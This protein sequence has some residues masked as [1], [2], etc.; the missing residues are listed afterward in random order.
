[1]HLFKLRKRLSFWKM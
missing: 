1:M